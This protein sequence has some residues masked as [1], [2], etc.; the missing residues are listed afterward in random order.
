M[1]AF[2]FIIDCPLLQDNNGTN[3]QRTYLVAGYAN[4]GK[5]DV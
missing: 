5:S 3:I 1:P 4:Y 2:E